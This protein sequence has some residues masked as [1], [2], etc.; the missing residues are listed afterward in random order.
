MK[1][2]G[3][4]LFVACWVLLLIG[5]TVLEVHRLVVH[6]LL[7]EGLVELGALIFAISILF[8]IY[9]IGNTNDH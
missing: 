6:N 7:R 5:I 8:G 1:N 3:F 4:V 9:S 2:K